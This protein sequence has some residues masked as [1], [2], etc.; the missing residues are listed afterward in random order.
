MHRGTVVVPGF[1]GTE[2]ANYAMGWF[3]ADV[4]GTTIVNHGGTTP[5]ATTRISP[6]CR[7]SSWP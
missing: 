1:E 7:A 3:T 4:N 2:Q 5:P 6:W